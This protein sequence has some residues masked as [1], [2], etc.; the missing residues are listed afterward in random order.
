MNKNN[1][2]NVFSF[3]GISFVWHCSMSFFQKLLYNII[4]ND[5]YEIADLIVRDQQFEEK[6]I[7]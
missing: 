2:I 6:K 1:V 3:H 5:I 7:G 4:F